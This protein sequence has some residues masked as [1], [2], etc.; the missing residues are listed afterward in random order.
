M[1]PITKYILEQD[2][3]PDSLLKYLKGNKNKIVGM[4]KGF[5]KLEPNVCKN[6]KEYRTDK[7]EYTALHKFIKDYKII[8]FGTDV[9]GNAYGYSLKDKKSLLL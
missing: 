1:D 6:W 7:Y 8:M 9:G 2:T 4:N 5:L 3:I